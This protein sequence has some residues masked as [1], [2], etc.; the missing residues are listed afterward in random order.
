MSLLRLLLNA[1]F[2]WVA[3]GLPISL[4]GKI[5][6]ALAETSRPPLWR[7]GRVLFLLG[8]LVWCPYVLLARLLLIPVS[9]PAVLVLHCVCLY[10][11]LALQ[12]AAER[13]A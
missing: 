9:L 2:L 13:P 10:G 1:W 5:R 12:K 4:A 8:I 11:G 7:T 6:A 3:I